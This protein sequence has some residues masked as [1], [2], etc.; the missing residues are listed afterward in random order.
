MQES[1]MEAF[2]A[3]RKI[4]PWGKDQEQS[5]FMAVSEHT[6]RTAFPACGIR[7]GLINRG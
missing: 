5:P 2:P 1:S 7:L 6:I 4:G 3:S